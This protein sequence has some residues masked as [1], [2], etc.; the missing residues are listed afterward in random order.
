MTV[1]VLTEQRPQAPAAVVID[2]DDTIYPQAAYLYG[3]SRA[4]GR[5]GA[6]AGLDPVRLARALRRRLLAGSDT[7]GTIDGALAAYGLAPDRIAELVPAL[8]A[9]FTDY[10]PR[11]LPLYRG[12]AAALAALAGRYPLVCL[13]DGN[14]V[15]QRA[16]LAAT[17]VA[18]AFTSIVI[19][20]ELGGRAVRKP[21]PLGLE[22]AAATLGVCPTELIM[23]GDRPGKDM[24]VAAAVGARSIRVRTG[25]Y[26]HA[27][28]D[29]PATAVVPNLPTAA[30]LLLP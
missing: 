4:V 22:R 17:G 16:K 10:R 2:L 14:P 19:T 3:A 18:D 25:E 29:P 24:A 15:I 28:D 1:T 21:H 9:A 11:R 26:A 7:G 20:D 5:A 6:A 23:V 8:V 27:P 12:A 13:T 30:T